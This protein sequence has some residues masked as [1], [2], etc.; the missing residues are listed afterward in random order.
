MEKNI[1]IPGIIL[2]RASGSQPVC[3]GIYRLG[4]AA[5]NVR[6]L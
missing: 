4:I 1:K 5:K 3:R 6:Y 2:S